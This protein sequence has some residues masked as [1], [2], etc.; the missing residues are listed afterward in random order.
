LSILRPVPTGIENK[1]P[2]D[3]LIVSK[4]DPKGGIVSASQTFVELS[5]YKE[6]EL[7][8]SAHS[9]MRHPDMPK[10]VFKIIWDKLNRGQN[11]KAVIKNLTKCGNHFWAF[12]SIEV[13]KDRDSGTIRNYIAY[14]S[15][16]NSNVK[17]KIE[18]LYDSLR[19]IEEEKGME[20]TINYLQGYLDERRVSYDEYMDQLENEAKEQGILDKIKN[21]F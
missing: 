4:T 5:G 20:D 7:I 13:K 10:T 11:V 8:T 17:F 9:L 21:I 19:S 15:A 3:T 12:T 2:L 6:S 1:L 18:S 14:R 16:I